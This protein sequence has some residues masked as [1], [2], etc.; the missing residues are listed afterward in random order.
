MLPALY[1]ILDVNLCARRGLDPFAVFSAF[2]RGGARLIQVRDKSASSGDRL[3]RADAFVRTAHEAGAVLIVND[4]V[5]IARMAGADGVHLGQ[6]DLGVEEA[7]EVLGPDAIVGISTHDAGQ[8]RRAR[9]STAT[10]VA[11]G[12][13]YETATKDTGYSPR[14]LERLRDSAAIL[15]EQG[16]TPKPIVAIGGIT[17]ARAAEVLEAGAASVAVISDLLTGGDPETRIRTF[18]RGLSIRRV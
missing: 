14:G 16:H 3:S 12:P 15:A 9:A 18:V 8:V 7:R 6:D 5:D 17:L 11:V 13:I 10:Y 4:R 1:A 2:L